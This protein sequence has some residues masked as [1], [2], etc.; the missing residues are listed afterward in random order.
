[1]NRREFLK[2]MALLA[3]DTVLAPGVA[4][5]FGQS[6]LFVPALA[7]HEGDWDCRMD[8][9]RSLAWELQRRTSVKAMPSPKGVSLLSKDLFRHPFLYF[10]GTG[11][12]SPLKD[13][14]VRNL[15]RFLAM[16]GFMLADAGDGSDGGGFDA[17][18]RRELAR[19]FP[20]KPLVRLPADHVAFKSYYLLDRQ[21]GR[22]ATKPFLWAMMD[23]EERAMV[24]YSQNDLAGALQRDELGEWAFQVMPGGRQQRELAIRTAVNLAMYALCLDY[25][26]D[27]LHLP[28]L[29]KRR[30]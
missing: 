5:A 20:D 25:K 27:L 30:Q 13:E 21:A 1:M 22:T 15:R 3:A 26:S 2:A 6:S 28:Y 16:G 23:E 17:S 19:L 7:R 4:H 12:F 8:A 14:E 11:A 24:V 9:M 18:M 29:M 10:G